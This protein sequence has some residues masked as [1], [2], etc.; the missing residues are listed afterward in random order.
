M[1]LIINVVLFLFISQTYSLSKDFKG[2]EYR[3]KEAYLYG[4]FE[5][6]FKLQQKDGILA[7]FFTYFTGTDS[8]PWAT[9]KWNEIDVEILGRYNN[10]VQFNTITPGQTNHVRSNFVNFDPTDDYHTYG[11]EWTPDY[12]AWFIDDQEVYRQTGSH[13]ST[14][15]YPQKIMM[16]IWN[17]I[18]EDWVGDFKPETL[19]VFAHYDWVKYYSYTPGSGDSGTENNFS[20]QWVDDFDNFDETRWSKETHTWDGNGC[21]FITQN[22]V[23][24]DGKLVLCLTDEIHVGYS[25]T[26]PPTIL[27]IRALE[28]SIDLFFS[29]QVNKQ[30][31]ENISSYTIVGITIQKAELLADQKTVRLTVS[32]LDSIKTYNIITLNIKDLAVIPNTMAGNVKSFSVT[33]ELQFPIKINVGGDD[34][35]VFLADQEWQL[36]KEYGFTEGYVSQFTA[37]IGLTDLDQIYRTDRNGLVSYKIR[38]PNGNY[39]LKLMFSEKYFET[40]G[41]RIFDV[42]AEGVLLENNLDILSHVPKNAAYEISVENVEVTDEILEFNFSAELDR[43]ILSGIV[44][45]K[46]STKINDEKIYKDSSSFE[47]K[48]N[49]P[50]P[51][52]GSTHIQFQLPKTENV[53]VKIYDIIGNEIYSKELVNLSMGEHQFLW[54]AINNNGNFVNS[55]VYIVNLITEKSKLSKKMVYLK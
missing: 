30:S 40:I 46:I 25:D 55:G 41:K 39:N 44:I 7:S 29:E 9:G 22:A 21:D 18:Y 28:N 32:D 8:I 52:N 49:Y 47:L 15:I 20:F 4:R 2:A 6:N 26:T 37:S 13:I 1:K 42:H 36:N 38:V 23:F 34:Q 14:L 53:S 33:K 10:N 45:E 48:Q 24:N 54:N 16:N 12:V 51:F 3:T 11:F 17:P 35:I 5:A 50:N 19:P 43:A 27:D 31:A